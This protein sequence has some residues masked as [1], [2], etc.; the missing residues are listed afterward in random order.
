MTRIAVRVTRDGQRQI[1]GGHPWVFDRSITSLSHEGAP[2]DLAVVFDDKRRFLAIGLFDPASPIRVRVLHHGDPAPIDASWWRSQL[3]L[4][5]TARRPLTDPGD[6]TGYRVLNGEN[7]GFGG[8][9]VDRFGS[10]LVVKCYSTAWFVHLDDVVA[11]LVDALD[12]QNVV[13]RLARNLPADSV[14]GRHDGQALIGRAVEPAPFVEHGLS[15]HA[16]PLSG[17]K[18]GW[19][20]DQ[21]ANRRRTAELCRDARVLDV[22]SAGG[23]FSVHAAAG[24]AASVDSIDSSAGRDR[25]GEREPGAQSRHDRPRDPPRH[26]R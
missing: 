21:R 11:A 25:V 17:Q 15:F 3:A 7:D 5:L 9:V 10:T 4:A 14:A 26:G 24:G 6:V 19:F 23:G 2:G 8:L 22:F 16:L 20:L 13:L 1:R 12:P 18:T